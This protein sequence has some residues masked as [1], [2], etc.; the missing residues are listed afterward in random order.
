MAS[1]KLS[2]LLSSQ[3]LADGDEAQSRWSGTVCPEERAPSFPRVRAPSCRLMGVTGLEAVPDQQ[4]RSPLRGEGAQP[5]R[6]C[7]PC[8]GLP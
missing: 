3:F 7:S 4:W 1:P 2:R 5:V 6:C 8:S